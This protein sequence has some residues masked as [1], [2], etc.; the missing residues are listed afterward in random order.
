MG[1]FSAR[2][3]SVPKHKPSTTPKFDRAAKPGMGR[4]PLLLGV[5]AIAPI[6]TMWVFG[7]PALRLEYRWNGNAN[8]PVFSW[9]RYGTV[10]NGT[11]ETTPPYALDNCP[12]IVAAHFHPSQLID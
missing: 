7:Q 1:L 12:L 8:Y 11:F 2:P 3:D 4:W 9:C 10:F 5:F 6:V